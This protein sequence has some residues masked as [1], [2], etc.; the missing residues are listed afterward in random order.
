MRHVYISLLV[1]NKQRL[2]IMIATLGFVAIIFFQ[3][4]PANERLPLIYTIFIGNELILNLS[5][6]MEKQGQAAKI[7]T[8]LGLYM[9]NRE[10]IF[11]K[12]EIAIKSMLPFFLIILFPLLFI[13]VGDSLI[14]FGNLMVLVLFLSIV[15]HA[16][17]KLFLQRLAIVFAS[18]LELFAVLTNNVKSIEC[19]FLLLFSSVFL[20]LG[21]LYV[22]YKRN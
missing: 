20:L 8:M 13:N 12:I 2:L 6:E 4:I 1:S 10:I 19:I 9:S 16:V 22:D 18:L 15:F 7:D 17:N 21:L 5:Y 14:A 3:N 11:Y